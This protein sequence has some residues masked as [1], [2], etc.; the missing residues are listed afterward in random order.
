MENLYTPNQTAERLCVSEMTLRMHILDPQRLNEEQKNNIKEAF[1]PLLRRDILDVADE[2]EQED[3]Q[4]FDDAIIRSFG[5]SIE[6]NHVYDCLLRLV[7]IRQTATEIF[8]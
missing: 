8:D 5:L 3:R 4:N 2:L 7:E 6:R 1:L